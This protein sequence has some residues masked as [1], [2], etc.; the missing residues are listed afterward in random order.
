MTSVPCYFQPKKWKGQSEV[1]D[2][3]PHVQN[4][5]L[6]IDVKL[7]CREAVR[8][9]EL[10]SYG[11]GTEVVKFFEDE[12]GEQRPFH[13]VVQSYDSTSKY[14]R[15]LYE[16]EDEEDLL[17][18]EVSEILVTKVD[19]GTEDPPTVGSYAIHVAICEY[20]DPS[21]LF[22]E[23]TGKRVGKFVIPAQSLESVKQKF[24]QSL[25]QR[26]ASNVGHAISLRCPI[27]KTVIETPVRGRDCNHLQCFDLRNFLHA[28][29]NPSS[30]RW[31]CGV[32]QSFL[33]CEDLVRCGLFDAM[34][35]DLQ[36]DTSSTRHKVSFDTSGRW[37]LIEQQKV[38]VAKSEAEIPVNR[39]PR[40]EPEVIDLS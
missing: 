35:R 12:T 4:T 33:C 37:K 34:L 38:E 14:Y 7:C 26:T 29:K 19:H 11:M 40:S 23:L 22:D 18:D 28:N 13:G 10:P 21:R 16:D 30:G 3:T 2:L 24:I 8:K 5:A 27:G 31:R 6:P 9:Q 17:R 25:K 1:L 20:A 15:I 32:C 39:E 36:T